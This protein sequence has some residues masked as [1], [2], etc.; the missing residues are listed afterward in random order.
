L[1][2]YEVDIVFDNGTIKLITI[3][4]EHTSL[5][6]KGHQLRLYHS[7]LSREAFVK[8]FN[9]QEDFEIVGTKVVPFVLAIT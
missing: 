7:L 5:L 6:D 4:E 1:G 2:P 9:V 8:Y 3:D